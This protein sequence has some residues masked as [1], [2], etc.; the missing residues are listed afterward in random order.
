[1]LKKRLLPTL[2]ATTMLIS[3]TLPAHAI[4]R[5]RPSPNFDDHIVPFETALGLEVLMKNCSHLL[6]GFLVMKSISFG[7]LRYN[8]SPQ[9][10]QYYL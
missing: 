3:S 10:L 8:P 7:L 6:K 5:L 2:L 4:E 9:I 1:M